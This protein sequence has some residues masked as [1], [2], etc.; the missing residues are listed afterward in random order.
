MLF[1][2][3]LLLLLSSGSL[4]AIEPAWVSV[5]VGTDLGCKLSA[6]INEKDYT[7]ER[8]NVTCRKKMS[9]P[10]G[11]LFNR[12]VNLSM[13]QVEISPSLSE[14]DSNTGEVS[15][16][17]YYVRVVIPFAQSGLSGEQDAAFFIFSEEKFIESY[18][19]TI[20]RRNE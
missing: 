13:L 10:R 3:F 16:N 2:F 9:V 4:G 1:S 18:V 8:L 7:L 5:D 11:A 20:V 14:V 6:K 12:Q 15:P 17:G 19:G